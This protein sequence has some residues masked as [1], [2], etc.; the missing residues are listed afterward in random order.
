VQAVLYRRFGG[1]DV[2][3]FANVADP[4]PGDGQVRI[5]LRATSVVP[6]DWKLRAGH[7]SRLFP[8]TFPKIPGRSGAGVVSK[9]GAGVEY[10]AP[11]ARVG[12]VAQHGEPGTY[13]QAIVRD[14][15]SIVPLPDNIGFEEGAALMHAGICAWI[16]LVETAQLQTG[17]HLLVHGGAGAIGGLAVQLARHLGA[18]VAATCRADNIDYVKTLGADE[19]VAYDRADFTHKLRDF[20]VVLDLIGGEVHERSYAVLKRGGHMVCLIAAP[21]TNQAA[22]FGVRVTT[23]HIHDS[24][25]VMDA[26]VGLTARGVLRPQICARLTLAHAAEAHRR[27]EANAVTRGR[28]ILQVPA[29]SK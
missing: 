28:I 17:A 2:L 4:E 13:A 21:F 27:L 7:L 6:A 19:V 26:V 3:E 25:N 12:I 16:C 9:L 15:E 23:P 11:G 10:V 14:R 22:K 20:D 5:D 1:P 24:R 18:Q 29:A 8:V